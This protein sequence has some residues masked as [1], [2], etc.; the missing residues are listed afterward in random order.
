MRIVLE[1]I[2]A[3]GDLD[4]I[5]DFVRWNH[6][7]A[8]W[9]GEEPDKPAQVLFDEQN[10]KDPRGAVVNVWHELHGAM[11][12]AKQD[13]EERLTA[14]ERH[15]I[16][17]S[18]VGSRESG[19]EATAHLHVKVGEQETAAERQLTFVL[20]KDNSPE[21]R[22]S[23]RT[24]GLRV[25]ESNFLWWSPVDGHQRK[26]LLDSLRH[27]VSLALQ[28][29]ARPGFR[30]SASSPTGEDTKI[31]GVQV[32]GSIMGSPWN[33]VDPSDPI[34][35]F[36]TLAMEST[37]KLFY[38]LEGVEA[39]YHRYLR[40]GVERGFGHAHGPSRLVV[41]PASFV[42]DRRFT[43]DKEYG[44]EGRLAQLAYVGWVAEVYGN[45]EKWRK[46]HPSWKKG[47]SGIK[48]DLMAEL[49]WMRDD[50]LHNSSVAQEKNTGRCE[51]LKWF[52]PG[53]QMVFRLDHV[54]EF[55]HHLGAWPQGYA[56]HETNRYVHWVVREF[57]HD[58]I[59]RRTAFAPKAVSFV[60]RKWSHHITGKPS[61]LL[62]TM[63]EDGVVSCGWV[64]EHDSWEDQ[65]DAYEQW[66]SA[67]LTGNGSLSDCQTGAAYS[68]VRAIVRLSRTF[69]MAND[70]HT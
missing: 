57:T 17:H 56:S 52:N 61:L 37:H 47:M 40:D 20:R 66:Q 65:Q 45:W 34:V 32:S 50:L 54:L 28:P 42:Y 48:T 25:G 64:S 46:K 59:I 62:S 4:A 9:T 1:D 6:P 58:D 51:V 67:E 30:P 8:W 68:P 38:L 53:D 26:W 44:L 10:M 49:G 41:V 36:M 24:L 21:A 5:A 31:G 14:E 27:Q 63:Y 15:N 23:G 11:T 19:V 18:G 43:F 22:A 70:P 33:D 13:V 55:L 12:I 29:D 3:T 39:T 60:V 16:V 2:I 69:S 7:S 35:D